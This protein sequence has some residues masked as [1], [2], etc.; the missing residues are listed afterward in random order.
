ML[1]DGLEGAAAFA[2]Q[3][4][5]V[6]YLLEHGSAVDAVDRLGRTALMGA[7]ASGNMTL[8]RNLL[9]KRASRDAF[10]RG[11]RSALTY[12]IRNGHTAIAKLL[13]TQ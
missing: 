3:V 1:P 12:A 11:G 5:L 7:A 10:D 2:D 9:A 4:S 8:V 13:D 6:Q